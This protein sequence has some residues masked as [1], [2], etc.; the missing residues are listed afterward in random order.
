[1]LGAPPAT[2]V[3]TFSPSIGWAG[4]GLVSTPS[5]VNV[6]YRA[7]LDGTLLSPEMLA[8]MMTTVPADNG[9]QYGLGLEGRKLSCGTAWGHQGNFPGYMVESFSSVDGSH[10]V[11]A[12]YNLDPNSM[13]KPSAD[14]VNAVRDHA[15]C[16]V[17]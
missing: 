2:D 10:Q 4:G 12:A 3:T 9:E 15:F 17:S 13:E 8:E 6:F 1:M 7:L 14:A 11:T 16:G 5:E